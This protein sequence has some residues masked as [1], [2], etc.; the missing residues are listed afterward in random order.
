MGAG[1]ETARDRAPRVRHL[2]NVT[3]VC[4]S[5]RGHRRN[6][7]KHPRKSVNSDE[8][9]VGEVRARWPKLAQVRA[10]SAYS[11][12]SDAV[13]RKRS[14]KLRFDAQRIA[15]PRSRD[16]LSTIRVA[17][18]KQR[19]DV[20]RVRVRDPRQTFCHL[21]CLRRAGLGRAEPVAALSNAHESE[22]PMPFKYTEKRTC[23]KTN[24]KH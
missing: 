13:R 12:Q 4:K 17:S 16:P 5:R 8:R 18:S 6:E 9:S 15:G 23:P 22:R 11:K 14:G 10:S 21:G 7:S 2:L 20:G 1:V 24:P 19:Q 3:T